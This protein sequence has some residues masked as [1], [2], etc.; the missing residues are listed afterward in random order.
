MSP[1]RFPRRAGW[2]AAAATLL[3][4]A[5]VGAC[6]TAP[7]AARAPAGDA[8]FSIAILGDMPYMTAGMPTYAA[9][10][11]QYHALLDTI[12]RRPVAA[13][14]HVGDITG[15]VCSDSLY[16]L[17]RREFD[18]LPHPVLY[19]PGDNEWTD[20]ARNGFEPLERLAALRRVFFADDS[21]LGRRR[22]A[23]E[24]QSAAPRFGTYRENARWRLG[25]VRFATLHVVG[26]NDNWGRDTVPSAE[27]TARRIA[28][29]A[30]LDSTFALAARE[31]ARGVV[32]LMQANPNLEGPAGRGQQRGVDAF[33]AVRAALQRHAAA[34]GGPVALVH[35]DS[36]YFRVDKPF[37][38]PRS[39]GQL[40]NL[41]RAETFGNPS[42]HGLLLTVEPSN[43]N[44]F[45]FEPILVP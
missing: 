13:V 24:R 9:A 21:S 26:S 8:P 2:R 1:R 14:V 16:A 11:R 45:R 30:W 17:R 44:L 41:T 27:F 42:E 5:L 36:H 23:V 40:M 33:V 37:T 28:T 25:A 7:R 6:R 31:R 20:C 12:A 4:G 29:L 43:P 19:T 15:A 35:G 22:I 39:G 3:A 18:A 10:E 34:F 32:I 38:D